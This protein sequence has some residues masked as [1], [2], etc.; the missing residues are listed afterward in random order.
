M[1]E[2]GGGGVL[3]G[4]GWGKGVG[5]GGGAG[6]FYVAVFFH[7][8]SLKFY[9]PF[10]C[11]KYNKGVQACTHTIITLMSKREVV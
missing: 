8:F 2:F 1:K 10:L 5:G 3:G 7:N 9:F 11:L 4:G 6:F